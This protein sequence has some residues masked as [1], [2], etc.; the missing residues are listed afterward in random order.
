[1][2]PGKLQDSDGTTFARRVTAGSYAFDDRRFHGSLRNA[3]EEA[4]EA[5]VAVWAA[6]GSY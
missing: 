2:P 6:V 4:I 5:L 3:G 1:M